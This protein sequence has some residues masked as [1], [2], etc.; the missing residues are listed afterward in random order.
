M[1][2]HFRPFT[3]ATIPFSYLRLVKPVKNALP[4]IT[5]LES[6]SNRPLTFTFEHQLNSL[7]WFHLHEHESGRDLLQ[8]LEQDAF[9][10]SHIAPPEGISRGAFFE[11]MNSR[12]VKQL[13]EMYH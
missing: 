2:R 1:P 13:S 5:P 9:A 3:R 8:V 10:R 11:A 7:I 4:V 6:R 12:G